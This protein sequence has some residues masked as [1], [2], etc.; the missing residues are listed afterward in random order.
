MSRSGIGFALTHSGGLTCSGQFAGSRLPEKF[1]V[2]LTCSDNA[3]SGTMEA[4]K[5]AEGIYGTI[6]LADGRTG[7]VSFAL[8]AGQRGRPA[9]RKTIPPN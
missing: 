4:T 8:P 7:V 2:P 1:T 3:T 9:R 6:V 5:G